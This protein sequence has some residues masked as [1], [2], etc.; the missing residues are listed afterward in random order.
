M[1]E[2]IAVH[3]DTKDISMETHIA[4]CG[5]VVEIGDLEEYG[6][7]PGILLHT[8]SDDHVTIIGI[9]R[10]QLDGMLYLK[11]VTVIIAS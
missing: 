11:H 10:D 3:N 5:Q 6:R 8:E 7:Q 2:S 9:P 1:I 4:V